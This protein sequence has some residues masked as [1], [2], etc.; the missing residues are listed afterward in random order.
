MLN[1]V[2]TLTRSGSRK[3]MRLS[4]KSGVTLGASEGVINEV[5]E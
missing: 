3:P 2:G 4:R 1:C 5:V